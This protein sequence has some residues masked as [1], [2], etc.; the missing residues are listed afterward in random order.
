MTG[1]P[2]VANEAPTNAA[3]RNYYDTL[4]YADKDLKF[5]PWLA[6]S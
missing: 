3:S 2:H 5:I 4:V 1:D 6:T